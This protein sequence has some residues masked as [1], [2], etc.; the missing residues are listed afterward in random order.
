[1]PL[2]Y[3]TITSFDLFFQLSDLNDN[4]ITIIKSDT[5]MLFKADN[6]LSINPLE[7]NVLFAFKTQELQALLLFARDTFQ[8]VLQIGLASP[9]QVSLIWNFGHSLQELIVDTEDIGK[10]L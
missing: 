5:E 10:L 3:D 2:N 8:N 4:A 1:M 7:E 9:N 6:K